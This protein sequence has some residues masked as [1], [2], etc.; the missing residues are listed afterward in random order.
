MSGSVRRTIMLFSLEPWGDMWYSK[1]HYAARLARSHTVYFVSPPDRWRWKHL[2]SFDVKIRD[3]PEGVKVVEYR[4]NLPL[5]FIKTWL[6]NLVNRLIARRL[7]ALLPTEDVLL[8]CFHPTP[9]ADHL[10][11]LRPQARVIYHVVDPFLKLPNDAGFARRASL[12]VA[13]NEWYLDY[14]SALNPNCLLVP[15]GVRQEDREYDAAAVRSL[16]NKWGRY[17]ILATGLNRFV[18]YPLL[19]HLARRFPRVRLVIAG[20]MFPLDTEQHELRERLFALPNVKYAGVKHPDELKEIIRGAQLGLLT[21]EFEPTHSVP[22]SAGRTPLKVLTYLAQLC[23]VVSTNNSYVPVLDGEGYFKA[24]DEPHFFRLVDDVLNGRAGANAEVVERYLDSVE[25]GQLIRRILLQLRT[26]TEEEVE[27]PAVLIR[28]HRSQAPVKHIP[29]DVPI[30]IISNEGWDGPRYSKHR[31]ALAL[32]KYRE[33]FFIDP[34]PQWK[35]AHLLQIGVRSR[36]TPEGVTVLSY[37]NAIPLFGG[38]LSSIN[39]RIVSR[40]IRRTLERNGRHNPLFWTFDPRRLAAPGIFKPSASVYH[41]ADDYGLRWRSE[42]MLAKSCDHV[43]CIARDLMPRFETMN[44]SVHYVPHGLAE[45]D[46]DLSAVDPARLPAPPG[47]GLFIGNINDRHDFVLW[48]KLFLANPDIM[49]LI[50]GPTQISD[51]VGLRIAEGKDFPNVRF[52]PPV[53]YDQL[54]A[55]IA[56]AGFGF[57]YLKADHPANMISSQKVVQ[58]LAQG[59]PFFSSWLS[60]YADRSDLVYVSEDHDSALALF[61]RWRTEGEPDSFRRKRLEYSS[62]QHFTQIIENLPFRL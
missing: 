46:M 10:A 44:K 59:K 28:P 8:W 60:E 13:I 34:P 9:L 14:Y 26:V 33:V 50:V 7:S 45:T 23:P 19:I 43:F 54:R 6:A 49:W 57:L 2:F 32:K 58:F 61:Q 4:N 56:G 36:P 41:C 51:P 52:L 5:R 48:E 21:Y 24:E 35:P 11:V 18:N 12:V 53:P 39:D 40:R 27:P 16:Q 38:M 30:L 47:Y 31:Y 22:V 17:M 55:L 25:Y 3:T 62:R 1:Q 29:A 15:H 42:R 37:N 20:Q